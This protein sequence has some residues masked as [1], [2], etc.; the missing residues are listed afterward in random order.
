MSESWHDEELCV[1]LAVN[2]MGWVH[3]CAGALGDYHEDHY[4]DPDGI[5]H[6]ITN[7]D[8]CCDALDSWALERRLEV[9]G[10][11][12]YMDNDNKTSTQLKY[13]V[14]VSGKPGGL[15]MGGVTRFHALAK[16]AEVPYHG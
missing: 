6:D 12:I 8:P 5:I 16:A 10:W 2:I 4:T 15:C 13:E 11:T 14:E 3:G 1:R 7:W 9:L